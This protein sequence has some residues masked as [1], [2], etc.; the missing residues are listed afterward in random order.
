MVYFKTQHGTFI[1]TSHPEHWKEAT[2]ITKT[3]YL[4]GTFNDAHASLLKLLRPG[5]I[6]YTMVTHVARS[7]MSRSIKCVY[8]KDNK[9]RDISYLIAIVLRSQLDYQNS[10][11]KVGGCGMDMCFHIVNQL[12]YCLHGHDDKG[13]AIEAGEAGRPFTPRHGHYRAGYSLENASL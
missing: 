13:E 8:I 4:S 10:G 1:E 11:V 2:R 6:I 9:P 12:S 3:E 5:S 7:G